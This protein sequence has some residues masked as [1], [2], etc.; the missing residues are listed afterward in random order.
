MGLHLQPLLL[1]GGSGGIEHQ[2]DVLAGADLV[3][4]VG[5]SVQLLALDT[6]F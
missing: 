1:G 5:G 6:P 3:L 4:D 2:I